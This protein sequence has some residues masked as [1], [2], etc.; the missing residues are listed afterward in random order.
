M[1][2]LTSIG[3]TAVTGMEE[4]GWGRPHTLPVEEEVERERGRTGPGRKPEEGARA[5]VHG[6]ASE[7][8]AAATG[9]CAQPL[10]EGS[11]TAEGTAKSR[12]RGEGRS[13]RRERGAAAGVHGRAGETIA[14]AAGDGAWPP[15]EGSATAEGSAE[16]RHHGEGRSPHWERGAAAGVHS[17]AGETLAAAALGTVAVRAEK[18]GQSRRRRGGTTEARGGRGEGRSVTLWPRAQ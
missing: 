18:P 13:P 6:R 9:D 7:T 12:H 4:K 14:A 11:A 15:R 8:L 5:G 3:R 17:R 10:G 2:K 1:P 16:S